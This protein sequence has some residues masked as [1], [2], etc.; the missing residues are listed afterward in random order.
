VLFIFINITFDITFVFLENYILR[1][2]EFFVVV[3]FKN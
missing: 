1:I 3:I 2:F